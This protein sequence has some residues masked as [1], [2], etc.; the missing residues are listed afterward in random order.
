LLPGNKQFVVGRDLRASLVQQQPA[1]CMHARPPASACLHAR[2][3][4]EQ[5]LLFH[6]AMSVN[7]KAG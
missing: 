4:R 7:P 2:V 3:N 5:Q 1:A 6:Q